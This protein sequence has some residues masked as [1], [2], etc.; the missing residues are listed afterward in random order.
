MRL[1]RQ[2]SSRKHTLLLQRTWIQARETVPQL[3][4]HTT[5][6]EDQCQAAHNCNEVKSRDSGLS[7]GREYTY[8]R[9]HTHM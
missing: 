6:T 8:T 9:V 1:E 5:L 3:E 4:A 7:S 2:F